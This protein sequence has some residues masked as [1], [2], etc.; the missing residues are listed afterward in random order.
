VPDDVM[1]KER[2]ERQTLMPLPESR[3]VRSLPDLD[4]SPTPPRGVSCLRCGEPTIAIFGTT[5]HSV[6]FR[7][8]IC[9]FLS[10]ER[11]G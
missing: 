1:T 4:P 8:V 7:C 10:V 3:A 6:I 9:D 2:V 11:R 5:R